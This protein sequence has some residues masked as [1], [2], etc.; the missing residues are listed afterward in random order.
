MQKKR[1]EK[2]KEYLRK[3]SP[4]EN[5]LGREPARPSSLVQPIANLQHQIRRRQITGSRS[6]CSTETIPGLPGST[7]QG[8][9]GRGRWRQGSLSG[10]PGLSRGL[11]EK[12]SFSKNDCGWKEG[13]RDNKGITHVLELYCTTN[14]C[15]PI[16]ERGPW[17]PERWCSCSGSGWY[18]QALR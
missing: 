7:F 1:K 13:K 12:P 16:S 5:N 9:S 14:G 4:I 11:E 15:S 6:A 10:V 18:D 3:H 17:F 8:S 2:N